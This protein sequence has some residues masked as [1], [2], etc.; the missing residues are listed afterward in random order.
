MN[1]SEECVL[2]FGCSLPVLISHNR[3]VINKEYKFWFWS[4]S[5]IL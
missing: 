5:F 3:N 2:P 4:A 1:V